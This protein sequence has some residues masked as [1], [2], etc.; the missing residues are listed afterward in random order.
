MCDASDFAIRIVLG[1]RINKISHEIYYAN[2]TLNEAQVN[3]TITEKEFLT[4]DF[5]FEKFRPYLIGSYIIVF[6]DH[7]TLKHLVEKKDAKPRLIRRFMLLEEFDWVIKDRNGF[8]N[9]IASHISRIVSSYACVS[10]ICI[11]LS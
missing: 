11:L 5:G 9:P 10:P 2:H 1:Q 4:I 6:I 3:Y 8:E 7:A